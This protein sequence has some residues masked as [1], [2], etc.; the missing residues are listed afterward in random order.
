MTLTTT[1]LCGFTELDDET[2][3]DHIMAVF[4]PED[5]KGIDSLVHEERQPLA[6]SCGYTA[7]TA[8]ELDTHF[9]R[10]FVPLDAIGTDGKKHGV[11]DGA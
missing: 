11:I 9:Y 4:A 10:A 1:C 6:C 3:A 2:F 7:I 5:S 8:E